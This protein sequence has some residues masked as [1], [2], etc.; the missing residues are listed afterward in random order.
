MV[1]TREAA[2]TVL[3]KGPSLTAGTIYSLTWPLV[4]RYGN[5]TMGPGAAPA[6]TA[7]PMRNEYDPGLDE[8]TARA[9]SRQIR[10]ELDEQAE[11][12]HAWDG[13]GPPPFDLDSL[14][15]KAAP[16]RYLLPL[17]KWHA[18][19]RPG[20]TREVQ[21]DTVIVDEA[22]DMGALELATALAV[23]APGG[24]LVCYG[25]PGQ[26]LYAESK[27][28]RGA[29]PAA[30]TIGGERRIL[31]G[32]HRCGFPLAA[33]AA[34]VLTPI[35]RRP[36]ETFA[37]PH[38]TEVH[39]WWPS[40]E[41]RYPQGALILGYSR[42]N[43][44][45]FVCDWGLKQVAMVPSVASKA[46]VTVCHGHAAKGAEADEVYLLPWGKRALA[47]LDDQEPSALRLLYTMLTR[48]RGRV[49]V[50]PTLLARMQ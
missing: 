9:G 33:V 2:K 8:Y 38:R 6:Y 4:R 49:H 11:R 46:R 31:S 32:G 35:W 19:G 24:S 12:L 39:E 21:Y 40:T 50:P 34:R 44:A 36:A 37:A 30:W 42:Q 29:L 23:V 27:G 28:A 16:L 45:D 14:N 13:Q 47:R 48:A 1:Y 15:P 26:A 3:T 17:A 18:A 7:R 10:S 5:G 43:A 22:Q 25:D 20:L 41:D